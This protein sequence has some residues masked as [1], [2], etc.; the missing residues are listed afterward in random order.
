MNYINHADA[1]AKAEKNGWLVLNNV[2]HY[3]TNVSGVF[4]SICGNFV[5]ND[6]HNK[7]VKLT[8]TFRGKKYWVEHKKCSFDAARLVAETFFDKDTVNHRIAAVIN[9]CETVGANPVRAD[10]V[11]WTN[12][13]NYKNQLNFSVKLANG[14]EAVVSTLRGLKT[15]LANEGVLTVEIPA[16]WQQFN[17][18][19]TKTIAGIEVSLLGDR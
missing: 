16:L 10:N 1:T 15:F 3:R 17:K 13:P 8:V 14:K 5:Y 18:T 7:P 9:W 6:N 4:L 2:R 19:K 12:A 11:Q